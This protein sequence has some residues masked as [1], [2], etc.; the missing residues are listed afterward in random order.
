MAIKTFVR[1]MDAEGSYYKLGNVR[2]SE[3][4]EALARDGYYKL[5]WGS[6]GLETYVMA[7]GVCQVEELDMD[8]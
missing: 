8:D 5:D 3:V 6:T 4:V 7:S 2:A 1:L